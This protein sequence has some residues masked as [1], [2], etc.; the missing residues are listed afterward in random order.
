MK[1][2]ALGACGSAAPVHRW[3]SEAQLPYRVHCSRTRRNSLPGLMGSDIELIWIG[4][5]TSCHE[6]GWLAS[7]VCWT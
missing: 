3:P 5:P 7:V 6:S 4:A 2:S 1:L